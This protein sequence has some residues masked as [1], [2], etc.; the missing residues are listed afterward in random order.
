MP[1]NN[2]DK[3][4]VSLYLVDPYSQI[5]YVARNVWNETVRQSLGEKEPIQRWL[6]DIQMRESFIKAFITAAK[7]KQKHSAS[8]SA[9]FRFDF[10][11][12]SRVPTLHSVRTSC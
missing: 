12:A 6:G 9:N 11:G 7:E 2:S 3:Y 10:S 4:C 5:P 8:L 1:C